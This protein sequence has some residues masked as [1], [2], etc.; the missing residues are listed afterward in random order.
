VSS[1]AAAP[2]PGWSERTVTDQLIG[3]RADVDL[4]PGERPAKRGILARA[5][6]WT[7]FAGMARRYRAS[8]RDF[9]AA[10]V[11]ERVE[12]VT[13]LS[14]GT[15]VVRAHLLRDRLAEGWTLTQLGQFVAYFLGAPLRKRAKTD[16]AALGRGVDVEHEPVYPAVAELAE[17]LRADDDLRGLAE[18]GDIEA[19]RQKSPEFG[20]AFDAVL[21]RIGH[22][23]PCETELSCV[24][25]GR[26]PE[27]VF[28][29]A[30]SAARSPAVCTSMVSGVSGPGNSSA[31]WWAANT[32]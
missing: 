9:A 7:R 14:D 28:T 27:L 23:G 2:P 26:R 10:A 25:F 5:A 16:L 11:A 6:A 8:V 19:V 15:L 24:P 1:L 3:P 18:W 22:R 30:L 4:F 29:A 32:G 13:A 12:D 17:L 21:A 20:A 31:V